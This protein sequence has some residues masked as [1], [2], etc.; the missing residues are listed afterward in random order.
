LFNLSPFLGEKIFEFAVLSL[1]LLRAAGIFFDDQ[2]RVFQQA[3]GLFP[4]Q[5]IYSL[6]TDRMGRAYTPI[7]PAVA[8]L[9]RATIVKPFVF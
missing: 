4:D 7:F 3:A 9:S 2:I 8:I 1:L 6:D 5:I